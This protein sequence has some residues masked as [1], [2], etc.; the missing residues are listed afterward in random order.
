VAPVVA[1]VA[2]LACQATTTA[3][4]QSLDTS[5]TVASGTGLSLGRGASGVLRQRSP[6]FLDVDVGLVFDGDRAMEWTAGLIMELE[7][8]VSVGLNPAL[9]RMVH[10]RKLAIY[11]GVG[12]PF[13]FAPFTLFGV[14]VAAGASYPVWKRLGITLELHADV[15]FVGSDLPDGSVLAKLDLSLGLRFDL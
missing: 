15:F 10:F 8:P 12:I 9:K 11:G 4:A 6:I 13:I 1:L 7:G 5:L 14:E 2:A 3:G